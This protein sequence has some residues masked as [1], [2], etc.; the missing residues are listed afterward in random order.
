MRNLKI[1]NATTTVMYKV[2]SSK[3]RQARTAWAD[4]QYGSDEPAEA[5]VKQGRVASAVK[6]EKAGV[7]AKAGNKAS[8]RTSKVAPNKNINA[9]RR[10]DSDGSVDEDNGADSEDSSDSD[11]N[12]GVELLHIEVPRLQAVRVLKLRSD[13]DY[14]SFCEKIARVLDCSAN[15]PPSSRKQGRLC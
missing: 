2:S 13:L 8:S 1:E 5:P 9:K 11:D 3:T 7:V 6:D 10:E 15:D 4:V 14:E 12:T